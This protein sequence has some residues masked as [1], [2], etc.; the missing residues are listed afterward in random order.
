MAVRTRWFDDQLEV[1]LGMPAGIAGEGAE[2]YIAMPEAGAGAPQQVPLCTEH[3]S[4]WEG[5]LLEQASDTAACVHGRRRCSL[6][7]ATA[8]TH[9]GSSV[10]PCS[11]LCRWCCWGRGWTP[12]PG[13]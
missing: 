3:L 5:M 13:A 6:L 1:A 10:G 9:Q 4:L 8:P 7:C 2:G 12:G 11:C